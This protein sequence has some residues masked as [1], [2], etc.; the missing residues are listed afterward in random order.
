MFSWNH[1]GLISEHFG[2]M[3]I[4]IFFVSMGISWEL[5]NIEIYVLVQAANGFNIFLLSSKD[6]I[7]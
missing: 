4:Y 1:F 6:I 5:L 3:G 7:A 2:N